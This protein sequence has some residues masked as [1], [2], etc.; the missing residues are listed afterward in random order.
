MIHNVLRHVGGIEQYGIASM[1]LF[2]AVFLGVLFW[3]LRQKKNHL[4]YM[5]R[6]PLEEDRVPDQEI[7]QTCRIQE[8]NWEEGTYED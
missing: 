5:A 8:P 6:V 2:G 4:E 7:N 3:A 1:C